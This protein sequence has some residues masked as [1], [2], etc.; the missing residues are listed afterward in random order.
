VAVEDGA[1]GTKRY[2]IVG[3][4]EWDTSRSE[5]SMD[6]PMGR[7]LPGKRVDDEVLV[8]RPKGDIYLAIVDVSVDP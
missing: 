6:S 3:T 8:K 4:D 7:A 1:G 2:R 5:I